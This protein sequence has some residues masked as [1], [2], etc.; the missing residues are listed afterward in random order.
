MSRIIYLNCPLCGYSVKRSELGDVP[1]KAHCPRC[2]R[3][4][5][6]TDLVGASN[7]GQPLDEDSVVEWPR[8]AEDSGS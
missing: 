3:H 1:D 5:L 8:A 4:G 7:P 6:S 2:R